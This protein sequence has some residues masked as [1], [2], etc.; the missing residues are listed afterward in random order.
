MFSDKKENRTNTEPGSAQNRI[1]EGT[2]LKGD[3][4]WAR[5]GQVFP[6]EGF[7][8]SKESFKF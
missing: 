4:E 3:V 6:N 2:K 7:C 8:R 1:N 5:I